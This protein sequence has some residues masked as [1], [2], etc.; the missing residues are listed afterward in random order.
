[1]QSFLT[2]EYALPGGAQI[3]ICYPNGN[4]QTYGNPVEVDVYSNVTWVPVI[5]VGQI[6][7]AATMRI[8]QDTSLNPDLQPTT[9]FDPST[10]MC[11]T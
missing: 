8:E 9:T 4:S 11:K 2:S 7:S 10:G 5:N 3:A 6:K 1:L